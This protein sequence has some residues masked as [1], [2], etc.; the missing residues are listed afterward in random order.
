MSFLLYQPTAGDENN[1]AP[2]DS[3]ILLLSSLSEVFQFLSLHM[4]WNFL[5]YH[6]LAKII[7][8]F[9][10]SQESLITE[11]RNYEADVD[12]FMKSTKLCDFLEA[13]PQI[14]KKHSYP[15]RA[16][17]I[18]KVKKD[19]NM[20]TLQDVA[21]TQKFLAGVFGL[22]RFLFHFC[23]GKN[24]C[25]ELKWLVSLT[26]FRCMENA[27]KGIQGVQKLSNKVKLSVFN[28]DIMY[29]A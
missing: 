16:V 2:K 11:L 26:A 28:I 25:V 27:M 13:W 9:F 7:R 29:Y 22:E 15:D 19:W 14:L 12:D 24:G 8:N 6:L 20:Y 10:N 18:T 1:L 4:Y 23:E 21:Q 3:E 5:N 17:V